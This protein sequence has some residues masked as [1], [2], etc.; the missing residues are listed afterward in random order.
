[1][2]PKKW[3]NRPK[4]LLI[5]GPDPFL[6]QSSPGHSPQPRS[7]F[8][9]YKKS[10]AILSLLLSGVTLLALKLDIGTILTSVWKKFSLNNNVNAVVLGR[11]YRSMLSSFWGIEGQYLPTCEARRKVLLPN[12]EEWWQHWPIYLTQNYR[13]H[14]VIKWKL[15]PNWGQNFRIGFSWPLQY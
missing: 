3:K 15:F 5:I 8:P 9:F 4:K 13:I 11:M 12:S 10:N 6:R 2:T 14:I 1:M 7:S